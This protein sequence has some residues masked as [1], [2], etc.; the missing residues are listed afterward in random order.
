MWSLYTVYHFWIRSFSGLR[1]E[2]ERE[3]STARSR[4]S[5]TV[6]QGESVRSLSLSRVMP[7]CAACASVRSLPSYLVPVCA[8][9]SF[10]R[11]PTVSSGLHLTRIF[12]PRRSLQMLG[13]GE[14]D[15]RSDRGASTSTRPREGEGGG[16]GARASV[17][18]RLARTL[19]SWPSQVRAGDVAGVVVT[20]DFLMISEV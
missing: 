17:A 20:L 19:R 9:S 13:E 1:R 8:A 11:S 12:L 5:A 10:F 14:A 16:G 6:C 18:G 2:R 4:R 3:S 7:A 15:A